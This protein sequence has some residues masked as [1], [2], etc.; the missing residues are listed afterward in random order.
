MGTCHPI[1]IWY[2]DTKNETK[3][4][5][6]GRYQV[7]DCAIHSS[8]TLMWKEDKYG[9][10]LQNIYSDFEYY[11]DDWFYIGSPE[12]WCLKSFCFAVLTNQFIKSIGKYANICCWSLYGAEAIL[13][14]LDSLIFLPVFELQRLLCTLL[15]W[16]SFL[17][18]W[19]DPLRSEKYWYCVWMISDEI[20]RRDILFDLKFC[21]V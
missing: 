15:F 1:M 19:N 6:G 17:R 3:F 18:I 14:D 13:F 9:L 21:R 16:S 8:G 20:E 4:R 12:Y 7:W 10:H 11:D 2:N 5:F